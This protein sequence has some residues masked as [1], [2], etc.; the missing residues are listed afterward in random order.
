VSQVDGDGYVL[1]GAF[2][3]AVS[4]LYTEDPLKTLAKELAPDCATEANAYAKSKFKTQEIK[5]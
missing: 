5:L 2:V 3:N 1:P 4:N